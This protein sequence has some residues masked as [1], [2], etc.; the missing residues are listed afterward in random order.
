MKT[1]V[2][3]MLLGGWSLVAAAQDSPA[4]QAAKADAS[5]IGKRQCEHA[6]IMQ[7]INKYQP[8]TP[9]RVEAEKELNA[10]VDRARREEDRD[11]QYRANLKGMTEPERGAVDMIYVQTL[12]D[13]GVR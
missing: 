12:G 2:V 6:L 4:V 13:C 10:V 7:R 9:E 11:D 1:M 3:G 8:G 5:R